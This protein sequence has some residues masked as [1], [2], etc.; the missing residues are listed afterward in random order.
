VTDN[1]RILELRRRVDAD[2]SS[3][4]FAQLADE[5]RRAGNLEAA[6]QVC[7]QGR[8]RHPGYLSARV[9]L[10]RTLRERGD[11]DAAM[12]ELQCVLDSAPDNLAAIRGIGEI[13]HRHGELEKALEYYRRA[14]PLARH[15][16]E[17][18]ETANQINRELGGIKTALAASPVTLSLKEAQNELMNAVLRL[19]EASPPEALAQTPMVFAPPALA[20][21]P[22]DS[23]SPVNLGPPV[24][25]EPPAGV[26]P[27]AADVAP[28]L[29]LGALTSIVTP[30]LEWSPASAP[31]AQ[32]S[33]EPKPEP[34]IGVSAVAPPIVPGDV[35]AR[36]DFDEL[37][38]ALGRTDQSAPPQVEALLTR[39]ESGAT[40]AEGASGAEDTMRFGGPIGAPDAPEP[41]TEPSVPLAPIAPED[42]TVLAELEAWLAAL[43]R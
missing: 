41:R 37:L 7:R 2:P 21:P 29:D 17:L 31:A 28:P 15:D 5:Y 12:Q 42:A 32:P 9:T 40:V 38:K 11:L 39:E 20:G 1:P 6:E 4:A 14:V 8:A 25:I 13:H 24:N 22:V 36:V 30:P 43:K 3:I 18:E 26:A 16:P 34:Q 27:P 10:G 19:A 33:P 35:E 23:A